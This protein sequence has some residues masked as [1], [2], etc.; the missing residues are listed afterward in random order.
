V[1][2]GIPYD[3]LAHPIDELYT[4]AGGDRHEAVRAC[5]RSLCTGSDARTG[6]DGEHGIARGTDGR[7]GTWIGHDKVNDAR[8]HM[9]RGG[10]RR[11]FTSRQ[12]C[13]IGN[14]WCGRAS[15]THDGCKP[16]NAQSSP[17]SRY[18]CRKRALVS[19]AH[20]A[21]GSITTFGATVELVLQ[22]LG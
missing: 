13:E 3:M 11:Q 1:R 16:G 15:C 7:V 2:R 9:L 19:D 20:S 8:D 4:C 10:R 18:F 5:W 6:G 14:S 12:S 22:A 21:G 17:S